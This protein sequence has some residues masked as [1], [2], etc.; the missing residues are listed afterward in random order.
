MGARI[1]TKKEKSHLE[2]EAQEMSHLVEREGVEKI[3][4]N[5]DT[6]REARNRRRRTNKPRAVQEEEIKLMFVNGFLAPNLTSYQSHSDYSQD[7][8]VVGIALLSSNSYDLFDSP[9]GGVG[10]CF[11]AKG[12]K[13]SHP[14]YLD[15]NS[16]EDDLL[17]EDDLLL[18]KT[19]DCTE[20]ELANYHASQ[21]KSID[22][23]KKEIERLTQELKTFKLD[24]ETTLEDHRELARTHEKLRFEKLNLEQENEF[25][26]A[27][28]DDLRKKSSSYLSKRLLLSN[29][30]T[31][32]KPKNT[33]NK[34]KKVSSSSNNNA[35]AK[36]NNVLASNSIDSTNDSLSQVTLE[37]END[38]LK[39]II[40][41]G[42][43]KSLAGSSEDS[44]NDF[45]EQSVEIDS[46]TSPERTASDPSS[47][48][49]HGLPKAAT[50]QIVR[51]ISASAVE[52]RAPDYAWKG[53]AIAKD[54]HAK[55]AGVTR[56]RK[57][58]IHLVGRKTSM[59]EGT[60]E[61]EKE[62][63]EEILVPPKKKKLMDDAMKCAPKPA[64]K[65]KKVVACTKTTKDI[66]AAVKSK[67]PASSAHAA[68]D[69]EDENAPVLRK[70]RPY[71][72]LQ[73]DAQPVEEDM[74]KRKDA[75]L[76]KWRVADPYAVRRRTIV[77]P[78]F[79]TKEQ[80][81]FYETV[82]YDKSPAINDMRYVDW[83]YIKENENFFPH[84]QENFRIVDIEDFVGKER[85]PWNDEMIMQFYATIHLYHE[86]LVW[87]TDGHRYD[88]TITEWTAIIGVPK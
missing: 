2:D 58:T 31:L 83:A 40:E 88:A 49:S 47:P 6:H 62:A 59:F 70:L 45:R 19:S 50:T 32:V 78:R 76:R 17:G 22:D 56:P 36:S 20:N 8:G 74:K 25:L 15:F 12:P 21:E 1:P 42:V 29:F 27:I 53:K 24:H 57:R 5:K 16:D 80:Q 86:S 11:M 10:N 60:E 48:S 41:R 82:L 43:F 79:H 67:G 52:Q 66:I 44:Q 55:K 75:G 9:N 65:A 28:N 34:C 68:K 84:V 85:T 23:D 37:Q 35:K 64:A 4:M 14:E 30:V 26:K 38:L 3:T 51:K 72:P 71:V 61:A 63:P 69:E 13:V 77:D 87:M 18:D 54:A 33:S 81:D 73:N 7:E 46:G 39:G